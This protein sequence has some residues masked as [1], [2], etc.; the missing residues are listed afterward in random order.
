M[1]LITKLQPQRRSTDRLNLFIDGRYLFPLP[2][3]LVVKHHLAVNRNLNQVQLEDL[4]FQATSYFLQEKILNY[5]SFRPHS[6]LEI[7]QRL[8]FYLRRSF[9][10]FQGDKQ[11]LIEFVMAKL[12]ANHLVD[13][14]EFTLWFLKSRLH[15][16]LKSRRELVQELKFKGIQADLVAQVLDQL[17]FDEA[18]VLKRLVA[19]KSSSY[20]SPQKLIAY[21]LRRG[22]PYR[23]VKAGLEKTKP[24]FV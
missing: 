23:L 16:K 12:K 4:N 2:L 3:E 5:L 17:K 7:K 9:A 22:F 15:S 1:P 6:S 11:K 24:D 13:D 20:S 10:Y 19:K 21:L 8:E 18:S 14:F